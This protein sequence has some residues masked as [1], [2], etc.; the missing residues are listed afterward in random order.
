MIFQDFVEIFGPHYFEISNEELWNLF[1]ID[2]SSDFAI[3]QFII[4]VSR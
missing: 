3:R 1:T 4:K 2:S